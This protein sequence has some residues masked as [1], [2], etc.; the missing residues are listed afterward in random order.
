[1][2]V[3]RGKDLSLKFSVTAPIEKETAPV[4]FQS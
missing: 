3:V 2:M 1:M 4:V